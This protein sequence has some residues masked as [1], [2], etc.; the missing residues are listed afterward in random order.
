MLE[1]MEDRVVKAQARAYSSWSGAKNRCYNPKNPSYRH[2]G[3]RGIYMCEKWRDDFSAFV[4]DMGY[5]VEHI[6]LDRIDNDGPY[7]PE[8][9]RWTDAVEQARNRRT[10][11]PV[12]HISRQA[13]FTP[14]QSAAIDAIVAETGLCASAVIRQ[15]VAEA[16]AVRLAE[17]LDLD[18]IAIKEG[19]CL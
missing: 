14:D 8:N 18:R 7:S 12:R 11:W 5:P 6:S 10:K 17:L 15:L 13:G 16:L 19:A 4:A 9:C 3:G 1:T 2:Y